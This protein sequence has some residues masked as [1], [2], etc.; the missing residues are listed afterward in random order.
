MHPRSWL[1]LP[2]AVPLLGACGS[3]NPCPSGVSGTFVGD[4]ASAED[5]AAVLDACA[6]EIDG[7]ISLRQD[8]EAD[9]RQPPFFR[10]LRN[11]ERVTGDVIVSIDGGVEGGLEGGGPGGGGDGGGGD[12]GPGE[13]RIMRKPP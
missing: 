2:L 12:G 1:V 6:A 9:V 3:D 4:V 5:A 7:Y 13:G 11:V 8:F 10:D